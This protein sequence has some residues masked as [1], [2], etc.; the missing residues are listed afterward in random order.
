MKRY[1]TRFIF[2]TTKSLKKEMKKRAKEL[3]I[4]MSDYLRTLIK[5]DIKLNQIASNNLEQDRNL[6]DIENFNKKLSGYYKGL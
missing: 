5:Q 2:Y 3:D 4:P 1:N 6:Y